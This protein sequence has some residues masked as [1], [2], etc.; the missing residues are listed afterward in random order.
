MK[1]IWIWLKSWFPS[2]VV[3][4]IE[5]KRRVKEHDG[6]HYY[7]GDLLDNMDHYMRVMKEIKKWNP[8]DY[9]WFS[10]IGAPVISSDGLRYTGESPHLRKGHFP[11]RMGSHI[12]AEYLH[13]EKVIYLG[14]L[15]FIK[16]RFIP[17]VQYSN[18]NIYAGVFY[19][20]DMKGK[21]K[22]VIGEPFYIAVS[23][24]GNI[25]VLRALHESYEVPKKRRKRGRRGIPVQRW[26]IPSS[27]RMIKEHWEKTHD[28]KTTLQA[29]AQ[30]F[31]HACYNTHEASHRGLQ[32]K[33][34]KDGVS[35]LFAI[36][37]L[38]TPYFFK[39]RI[40]VKTESG[41]TK[42]IFHI[43]KTHQRKNQRPDSFVRTHFR[44]LQEF[45]WVGYDV[46]II[47]PTRSLFGFDS[48]AEDAEVINEQAGDFCTSRQAGDKLAKYLKA[49]RKNEHLRGRSK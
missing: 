47:L 22:T 30:H 36:D 5:R 41:K 32:V 13:E 19:W 17:G 35:C 44:G 43:V 25:E 38:R 28:E 14:F 10:R 8:D 34:Q 33:V 49:G 31:F 42:P 29:V 15:S 1:Q 18:H 11:A 27:L 21:Y 46:K 9:D 7:L 6:V 37:M 45:N 24:S 40:K 4:P 39:D 23:E 20:D 48:V 12:N 3:I 26:R 16:M 2:E